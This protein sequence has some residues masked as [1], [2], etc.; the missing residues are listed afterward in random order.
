MPASSRLVPAL[1]AAALSLPLLVVATP[2]AAAAPDDLPSG[3]PAAARRA[4]PTLPAPKGWPFGEQFPRTSGTGRLAG[5][6]SLWTD[7]VYDDHGAGNG[8]RNTGR[9]VSS[10][11]QTDGVYTYA[12]GDA[13]LNGADVFR[14]AVGADSGATYWRVDWTTLINPDVPLAVWTVD[15]DDSTATGRAEWPAGARVSSPG[16][17]A[18]LV[19]SDDGALLQV[20]EAQPIRLPVTV[21]RAAR[22]FVVR[23][24]NDALELGPASRI[25]LGAG[26]SAPDGTTLAQPRG[27]APSGARL[28]NVAFRTVEQEPPQ[29]PEPADAPGEG[30]VL[31]NYWMEDA[32]AL[33]LQRGDVSAFSLRVAWSALRGGASTPEPLPRGYSNRW[34]VTALDLGQGLVMDESSSGAG[35]LRPN[36]LGRIQPYAVYVPSGYRASTPA[37][38][39]WVLHSLGV[40]HNQYGALNPRLLRD[41]CEKQGSICATT[42]GRGPDGWYFDEAEVDF[43]DVW[44]ELAEAYRLDP[45]RNRITGYSMGGYA[46]YKLGLAYVDL[47]SRAMGLAA[48]PRCG[49][50]VAGQVE[51]PAGPGRCAT[52]GSTTQLVGNAR[53]VPYVLA[54]GVADQ[55]VPFTSVL[56]Q[57]AAF[58][59]T[60]R[61]YHSMQYANQDHLAYAA[62]DLFSDEVRALGPPTARRRNPGTIDYTWYPNLSRSDFGIGTTGAYWLRSPAARESSPG[63]LARLQAT[64]AAL[65]EAAIAPYTTRE[66]HTTEAGAGNLQRLRWNRGETPARRAV[67]ALGLGNVRQVT[68][69]LDRAGL[70]DGECSRLD[71]TSD[72]PATLTLAGVARTDRVTVDGQRVDA[73][74]VPV[75]SGATPVTVGPASCAAARA[76][77]SPALRA[78]APG[79]GDRSQLPATGGDARLPAT[80]AALILLSLLLWRLSRRAA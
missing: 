36:V 16:I 45:E 5:G 67:V 70:R 18:S 63:S 54:N 13:A 61:R 39:T 32:Q 47:F 22:S 19:V 65:P 8:T 74:R 56:E 11:A 34:Y 59:R 72:G 64:S 44:R 7:F 62:A 12:E 29:F 20:G 24:P 60:G 55:L 50:R 2:A 30:S 48:P 38:L 46:A 40:Q 31:G 73:T 25:R 37:P 58:D 79:T 75:A 51:G 43:W 6:A 69:D 41:L 53:E 33:A 71:V 68:V 42:L 9:S 78:A 35:D 14:A 26:L 52:D 3:V 49:L 77:V 21:D 1:L 80:G 27:A 17:D 23:V 10:L 57:V 76:A 66:P 4:E 28:Y 15:T